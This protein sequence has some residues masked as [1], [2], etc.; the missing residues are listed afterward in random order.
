MEMWEE[1]PRITL[2]GTEIYQFGLYCMIGAVCAIMAMLILCRHEKLKKGTGALLSLLSVVCGLLFSRLFY[3]V[4]FMISNAGFPV[5]AWIQI[6]TGGWSMFGMVFG[7]FGASWLT[8]KIMKERTDTLADIVSCGL[9]LVIA[10]ARFGEKLF[11]GFDVSRPLTENAFPSGTFLAV[12]DQYYEETSY[13]AT[14]LLASILAIVLFLVLVA[15]LTREGRREGDLRI[16]FLLLCGAG[17]VLLESLRY[18]HF[19]EFSFVRFEQVMAAVLLAWGVLS[20]AARNKTRKGLRIAAIVSLIVVVGAVI[21]IEFA[22]D[23]SAVSHYLLYVLMIVL[24]AVPVTL[25]ILL[26][27]K[28]EKETE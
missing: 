8:A 4:L 22:L 10:A 26:L 18:D 1:A 14:W 11:E 13:L 7:V 5:S 16:L 3:S 12:R 15:A 25:G 23:R 9:P 27:T 2:F 28:R 19:L 21:G 17:G 24:L 6:T 20:A